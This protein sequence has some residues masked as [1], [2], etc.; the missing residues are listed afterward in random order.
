MASGDPCPH[1]GDQTSPWQRE[2][3]M[4]GAGRLLPWRVGSSKRVSPGDENG[5]PHSCRGARRARCGSW[6]APRGG[7]STAQQPR[8]LI[9]ELWG[10]GS[11]RLLHLPPCGRGHALWRPQ[12]S[13]LRPSDEKA[14]PPPGAGGGGGGTGASRW[15]KARG[16]AVSSPALMSAH[17]LRHART[18]AH[19]WA[20][21]FPSMLTHSCVHMHVLTFLRTLTHTCECE[22]T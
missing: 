7:G 19:S 17:T 8:W 5:V 9:T 10:H 20:H 11:P 21:T 13:R 4:R 14:A 12:C 16:A 6:G 2:A 18:H 22:L 1:V 3:R 15:M